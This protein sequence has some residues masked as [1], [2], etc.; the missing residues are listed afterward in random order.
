M[1]ALF[2]SIAVVASNGAAVFLVPDLI[3]ASTIFPP[4]VRSHLVNPT[5]EFTPSPGRWHVSWTIYAEDIPNNTGARRPLNGTVAGTRRTVIR[6]D[7]TW[8]ASDMFAGAAS[9]DDEEIDKPKYN[10]DLPLALVDFPGRELS[11]EVLH[12]STRLVTSTRD[13]ATDRQ[14]PATSAPLPQGISRVMTGLAVVLFVMLGVRCYKSGLRWYWRAIQ[15]W[16][17]LHDKLRELVNWLRQAVPVFATR[18]SALVLLNLILRYS[19]QGALISVILA[20]ISSMILDLPRGTSLFLII[21]AC[22]TNPSHFQRDVIHEQKRLILF[23]HEVDPLEEHLT[24]FLKRNRWNGIA[25][26]ASVL[27]WLAVLFGWDLK[28]RQSWLRYTEKCKGRRGTIHNTVGNPAE[29]TS[30]VCEQ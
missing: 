1:V 20:F 3:V 6:K 25:G 18:L 13:L 24:A 22:A 14:R 2:S 4:A 21:A 12:R 27:I 29:V 15:G 9:E 8:Y 28:A 11:S 16:I 26:L 5:P 30:L 7:I 17:I 19:E 10:I 23:G